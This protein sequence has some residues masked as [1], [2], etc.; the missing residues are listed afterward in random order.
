LREKGDGMEDVGEGI[1]D[2]EDDIDGMDASKM[3]LMGVW[4]GI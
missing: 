2:G 3:V 4:N 1:G